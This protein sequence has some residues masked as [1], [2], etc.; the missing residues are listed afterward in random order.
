MP[1]ALPT[2]HRRQANPI[3]PGERSAKIKFL[4]SAL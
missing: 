4:I 3:S 2:L 1:N